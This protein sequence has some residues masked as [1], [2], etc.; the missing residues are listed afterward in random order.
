MHKEIILP[1]SSGVSLFEPST[2]D[3]AIVDLWHGVFAEQQ[4]KRLM[5][6]LDQSVPW[7]Q[8]HII[9]FGKSVPLPRLTAWFGDHGFNYTYSG[10]QMAPTPWNKPL[11]EIKAKVEEI[12]ELRFNS[13]LLNKY[14]D[15]NDK[16]SWHSD[17][18]PELG[19]TPCIA[20]VSLGATRVFKLRPKPHKKGN[21]ST[22]LEL[23][24]GSVLVM[25]GTTQQ[26]WEHER[27]EQR[28][29]SVRGST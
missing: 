4:A 5:S 28:S 14:R 11:L 15:G 24:T 3:G 16:V 22:S 18:E 13:V 12:C 17:D 23:P 27:Q 21:K 9:F 10:I 8:D 20:S 7:R 25:A 29:R 2:G 1:I 6:D 19:P 26:C